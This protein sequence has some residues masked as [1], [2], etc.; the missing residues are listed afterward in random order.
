MNKNKIPKGI[1]YSFENLDRYDNFRNFVSTNKIDINSIIES[2]DISKKNCI[3]AEQVHG[4]KIAVVDK[5]N[6]GALIKGVDALVTNTANLCLCIKTA[7]CLPLIFYDPT[8]KVLAVVHAGWK[9]TLKNISANSVRRMTDQFKINPKDLIIGIGP[10]IGP[11]DYLV[12]YDVAG[13]FIE[14]G[15]R[16]FL[17]KVS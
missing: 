8:K 11:K 5:K 16:D 4:N 7:D 13:K 10:S 9:G 12:K 15:Y 6:R 1:Y 14:N 2:F 3:H 17:S